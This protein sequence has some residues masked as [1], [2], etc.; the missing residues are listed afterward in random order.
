MQRFFTEPCLGIEI[1][2]RA[3]R[4]GVLSRKNGDTGLVASTIIDVPLGMVNEGFASQPFGDLEGLAELLRSGM[5]Q[6]FPRQMRKAGLSLPDGLF[7]IQVLEFDDLPSGGRDRERLIRWRL[8][9][10]SSFDTVNTLLRFQVHARPDRGFS[11]LACLAKQDIIAGYE[12]LFTALGLE[13][14]TVAPSSLHALNFYAPAT[15]AKD[16]AG[17]AMTWI[18]EGSYATIIMERGGPRFYRY[19]EFRSG[20]P[21][22]TT[23]RL[24]REIDDSLH[25]YTHRDRTQ[26]ADVGRLYV[27][28][29][30]TLV[31]PLVED[32]RQAA[33][34][35]VEP[36]DPGKVTGTAGNCSPVLAAAFGAGGVLC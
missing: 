13:T 20:T 32:I 8:E 23:A 10:G 3:L 21:E 35:T 36:L 11:V 9:K 6:I 26:A 25:F 18:A 2:S 24:L 4:L 29:E 5:R 1:T 28:G 16:G 15:A 14:W 19:K 31:A 33:P 27:A 12:D 7:R 17:Y 22:E 30:P 34:L